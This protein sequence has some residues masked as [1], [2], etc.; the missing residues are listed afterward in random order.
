MYQYKPEDVD[1]K[2]C[3]EWRHWRCQAAG[4]PWL[5][6]RIEAGTVS[7]AG[8]I[9]KLFARVKH[10]E[11]VRRLGQLVLNFRGSL[12]LNAEHEFNTRRLLQ[13]VGYGAWRDPRYFA[14][15]YL[16]GSNRTLLKRGWNACLP[17]RFIPEYIWLY[18]ISPHDYALV[19][20]AKTILGVADFE[21]AMP[22]ELL[23]DTE[24]IDDEAFRLI[25]NALLI[26]NYGP[27]VLKTGGGSTG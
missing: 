17:Q 5:A 3:A 11:L 8:M 14:A 24:V 21:E 16:I 19:T 9:L 12:W 23:A 18:G 13:S 22:A 10:A 15:L 6:E 26:A 4:C 25:V 20:A 7:Y 1:C 27:A 2:Y